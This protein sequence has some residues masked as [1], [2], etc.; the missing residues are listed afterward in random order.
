MTSDG[1]LLADDV[2]ALATQQVGVLGLLCLSETNRSFRNNET[3][4]VAISNAIDI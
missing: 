3:Q 1:G 4:R 2:D